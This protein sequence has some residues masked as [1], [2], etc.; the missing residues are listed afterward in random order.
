[1]CVCVL[2]LYQF[3]LVAFVLKQKTA[4][5]VVRRRQSAVGC[6][7]SQFTAIVSPLLYAHKRAKGHWRNKMPTLTKRSYFPSVSV[8]L[9]AEGHAYRIP[10]STLWCECDFRYCFCPFLH[11]V[12]QFY[13]CSNWYQAEDQAIVVTPGNY[14]SM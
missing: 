9:Y 4:Q 8:C 12:G 2:N 6:A 14:V 7:A 5:T 11:P 1:M 3:F 10:A 13:N